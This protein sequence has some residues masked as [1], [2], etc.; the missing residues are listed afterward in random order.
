MLS[1]GGTGK[2][3]SF[4]RGLWP[5]FG[6][7]SLPVFQLP[8]LESI[9]VEGVIYALSVAHVVEHEELSLQAKVARI[10]EAGALQVGFGL[11]GDVT[12]VT[13][14]GLTGHGVPDVA[15]QDQGRCR[16][17]WVEEG[18]GRVWHDQHVAFLNFLEA[19]DG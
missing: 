13:A 8:S 19:A 5:R 1:V 16:G 14:I 11:L 3:P 18:R 4:G 10:G 7:S 17:I 6:A 2:Y 9:V 15:D 12:G